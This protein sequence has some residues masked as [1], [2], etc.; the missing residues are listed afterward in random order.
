M[1]Y[2]F[3]DPVIHTLFSIS[4]FPCCITTIES[5]RALSFFGLSNWEKVE[6]GK[7]MCAISDE[8][9]NGHWNARGKQNRIH[10]KMSWPELSKCGWPSS[11]KF[12]TSATLLEAT[13]VWDIWN[14]SCEMIIGIEVRW[15]INFLSSQTTS[16]AEMKLAIA[17]I[18]FLSW[19]NAL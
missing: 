10:W 8:K 19:I 11:C 13:C 5:E 4:F 2:P 9:E 7:H 3:S 14:S 1:K 6:R 15:E 12:K 16:N 17:F 18:H